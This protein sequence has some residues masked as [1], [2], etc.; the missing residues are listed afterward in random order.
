[1][2]EQQK[3]KTNETKLDKKRNDMFKVKDQGNEAAICP[4]LENGHAWWA[5]I[6]V[7]MTQMN[8]CWQGGF[9]P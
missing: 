8:R 7:Q 1:M 4:P 3:N 9:P 6:L 2:D 5:D